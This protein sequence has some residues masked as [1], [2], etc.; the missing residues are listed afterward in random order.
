MNIEK[1]STV[2]FS[3]TETTRMVV[4][5]VAH[6]ITSNVVH[7]LDITLLKSPPSRQYSV[8]ED[9][10][11]IGAPVYAGRIPGLATQ[12]LKNLRGNKTPVIA[13]TVYGNRAYDDALLE[14]CDC[15]TGQGFKVIGAGAF[16]GKHSFSSLVHPIAHDRP[17]EKDLLLAETFGKQIRQTL[18][19]TESVE[20][21]QT[22]AIPG[23]SPYKPEMHPSGAAGGT[24]PALCIHCG[25]CNAHCP[26][27]TIRMTGDGPVTNPDNCIWCTA[28]VKNCPTGARR[29]V[30]PKIGEIA[31]RL[32]NTCHT[33]REPEW[34]LAST[35]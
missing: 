8:K 5:A 21:L 27:H 26:A 4:R 12:R 3:P 28:C 9:L 23:Q 7:E 16:V 2:F 13:I 22:P 32:Y 33:R 18:R 24:D 25:Q 35:S 20:H 6:G 1:V 30:L 31:D 19:N 11:I 10:L 17:D 29:I 34:F 14:L 15:C